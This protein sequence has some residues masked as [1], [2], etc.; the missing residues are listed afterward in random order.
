[1]NSPPFYSL[2]IYH[3]DDPDAIHFRKLFDKRGDFIAVIAG[4][5]PVSTEYAFWMAFPDDMYLGIWELFSFVHQATGAQ[6]ERVFL[7]A[8]MKVDAS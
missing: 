2:T 5:T 8:E 3:Y 7:L 1:M 6:G 4:V